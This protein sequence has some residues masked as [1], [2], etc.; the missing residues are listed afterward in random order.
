MNKLGANERIR[1]RMRENERS[2]L[3]HLRKYRITHTYFFGMSWH[4]ALER[5][6]AAKKVVYRNGRYIAVRRAR[7]VTTLTPRERR[8][9]RQIEA[10]LGGQY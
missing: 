6:T 8:E 1:L 9:Y 3:A 10:R 7:P 5:L 4:N 2:L